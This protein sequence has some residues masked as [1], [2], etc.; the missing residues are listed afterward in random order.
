VGGKPK[1]PNLEK[2][3][4]DAQPGG[5]VSQKMKQ[6]KKAGRE[7]LWIIVKVWVF[8]RKLLLITGEIL[9]PVF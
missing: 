9:P 6:G 2:E 8:C 5:A 1:K 3:W 4:E 7:K